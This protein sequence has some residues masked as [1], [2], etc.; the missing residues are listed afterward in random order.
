MSEGCDELGSDT[1]LD[2]DEIAKQAISF[3][4]SLE[5]FDRLELNDVGLVFEGLVKRWELQNEGVLAQLIRQNTF[6]TIAYAPFFKSELKPKHITDIYRF[7]H[8]KKQEKK[9]KEFDFEYYGRMAACLHNQKI[10]A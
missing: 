1:P 3:G 10:E 9:E 5:E 6:F 8:E 7:S 2:F 4:M